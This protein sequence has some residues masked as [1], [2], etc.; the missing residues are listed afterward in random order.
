MKHSIRKLVLGTNPGKARTTS[1]CAPESGSMMNCISLEDRDRACISDPLAPIAKATR[2]TVLY[3][4]K[5]K[6]VYLSI[7]DIPVLAGQLSV[8]ILQNMIQA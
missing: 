6:G 8:S 5:C 7:P 3:K 1:D 4:H 2:N